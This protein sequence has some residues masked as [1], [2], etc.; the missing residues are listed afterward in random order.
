[1]PANQIQ[2]TL[3]NYVTS[4]YI[5]NSVR[6]RPG[7][8]TYIPATGSASGIPGKICQESQRQPDPIKSDH[9]GDQRVNQGG[10]GKEN[11]AQ[12][13]P[14]PA[15]KSSP[16]LKLTIGDQPIDQESQSWPKQGQGSQKT[17]HF[18]FLLYD[19]K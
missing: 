14:E 7:V 10:P 11:Q 18:I 2:E 12:E 4:N 9:R 3:S 16:D 17:T 6:L 19:E 13:R 15:V 5:K 8:P 1:L